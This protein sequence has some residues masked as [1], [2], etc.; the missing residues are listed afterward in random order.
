MR[1]FDRQALLN[2]AAQNALKHATEEIAL[3]ETAMPAL[4][5]CRVIRDRA[6]QTKP[7]EPPVGQIEMDTSSH[8]RRSDRMP[9]Q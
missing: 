8:R 1:E 5:E 9:K 3:P 4:G 7:A 6:I 2:A